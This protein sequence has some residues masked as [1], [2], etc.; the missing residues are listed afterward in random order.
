MRAGHILSWRRFNDTFRLASSSA[1]TLQREL[2]EAIDGKFNEIDHDD[3]KWPSLE[4]RL[5]NSAN[6]NSDHQSPVPRRPGASLS[7][8]ES[9]SEDEPS[10]LAYW[11]SV[12]AK[13]ASSGF[14]TGD[15]SDLDVLPS[16]CWFLATKKDMK[17]S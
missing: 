17:P 10:L 14:I 6:G 15:V 8:T 13:H 2:L 12:R 9:D 1:I 16:E 11:E 7:D 5:I 3:L 4:P